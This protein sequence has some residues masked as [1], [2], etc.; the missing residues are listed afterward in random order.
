MNTEET[1]AGRLGE[2][3]LLFELNIPGKDIGSKKTKRKYN[4]P[5]CKKVRPKT[6]NE[7][8]EGHLEVLPF[9]QS[10]PVVYCGSSSRWCEAPSAA[11]CAAGLEEKNGKRIHPYFRI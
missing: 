4:S 3:K 1:I 7:V 11:A 2:T 6:F 8:P 5:F 9:F 10:K